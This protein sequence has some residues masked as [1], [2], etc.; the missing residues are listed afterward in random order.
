MKITQFQALLS[1][2]FDF[3]SLHN[4]FNVTQT[5]NFKHKLFNYSKK[6]NNTTTE[7]NFH[8]K[9]SFTPTKIRTVDLHTTEVTA[10]QKAAHV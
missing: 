6:Y 1:S 5:S 3:F 9:F 10:V 7:T 8:D 2:F 4:T